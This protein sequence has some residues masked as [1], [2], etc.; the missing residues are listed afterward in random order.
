MRQVCLLRKLK[1]QTPVYDIFPSAFGGKV[2][3]S[4]ARGVKVPESGGR[5]V[6]V[7]ESGARSVT[8]ALTAAIRDRRVR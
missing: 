4:G 1:L 5:S 8:Y 2:P 7:P 6:K 3:E